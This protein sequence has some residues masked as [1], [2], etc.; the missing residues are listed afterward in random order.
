MLIAAHPDDEMNKE[1]PKTCATRTYQIGNLGDMFTYLLTKLSIDPEKQILN[2]TCNLEAS[3]VVQGY[4]P[5]SLM[6]YSQN[7]IMVSGEDKAIIIDVDTMNQLKVFN[8]NLR[9]YR[10]DS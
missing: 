3:A 6:Q 7:C 5:E 4:T 10:V 8:I 9:I 2:E 1:L